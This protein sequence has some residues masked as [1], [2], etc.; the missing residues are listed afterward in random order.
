MRSSGIL[1]ADVINGESDME[2]TASVGDGEEALKLVCA[3]GVD[4]LVMDLVLTGIDGLELLRQI[5]DL[6]GHRPTVLVVSGFTRGNVVNQAAALG[7]DF[8]TKPCRMDSITERI[9]LLRVGGLDAASSRQSLETLVTAIIHEIGVPAHIKGYQYLRE[10]ILHRRGRHGRHQRRHQGALPRGGQAVRHHRQ[11]GGAGHP[12]RHRGG[13]GP[14]RPGDAAEV[15]RLHRHP[16]PR[17]S[18]PTASSS[19]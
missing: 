13:L 14:G 7:A 6:S 19:P 4:V 18:P 11:P 1:L 16:T 10:A 2:V 15:F 3:G 5:G 17:A 8:M 9:R 12:P